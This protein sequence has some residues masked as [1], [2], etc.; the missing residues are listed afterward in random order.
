MSEEALVYGCIVADPGPPSDWYGIY[1]RNL[2]VVEALPTE[3]DDY[4]P[5]TRGLFTV[6]M[7]YGRP[8]SAFYRQQV[9]HF[10]ASFSHL[11]EFWHRWLPKFEGLLRRLYW[12]EARLHLEIELYGRHEYRWRAAWDG[13]DIPWH[14]VPPQPTAAWTFEGGPRDFR[15]AEPSLHP[16]GPASILQDGS[17]PPR[18]PGG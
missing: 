1:P 11:S 9:I 18:R 5:L 15:A 3:D 6:P 2:A 17:S 16:T 14:R 8:G 4:P 13:G 10:G 12:L 7:D